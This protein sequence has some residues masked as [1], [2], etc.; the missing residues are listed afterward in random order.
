M[1]KWIAFCNG[2]ASFVFFGIVVTSLRN[3][4]E[5]GE[6]VPFWFCLI[7]GIFFLINIAVMIT[8]FKEYRRMRREIKEMM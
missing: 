5:Q 2:Y 8:L 3:I 1:R 7:S 6:R 4:Y